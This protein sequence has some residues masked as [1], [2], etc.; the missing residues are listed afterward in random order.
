MPFDLTGAMT[1]ELRSRIKWIVIISAVIATFAFANFLRGVFT[2]LFWFEEV[3][4]RDVYLKILTTKAALFIGAGAVFALLCGTS[5]YFALRISQCP[6]LVP[7]PAG[8]KEFLRRLILWGAIV[9]V[10]VLSGVFGS[11]AA[12]QWALVMRYGAAVPFGITEP[13]FSRDAGFYV[14]TLPLYDMVQTWLLA[15]GIAVLI[16]TLFA[17]FVSYNFRGVGFP[18][19]PAFKVHISTIGASI[20]FA[21]AVGHWIDRMNIVLSAKGSIFGA[22]YTDVHASEPAFLILTFIAIACGILMLVNAYV[23]GLRLLGGALALW[24]V[25]AIAL[26]SG[27][28]NAMQRISV[29]PNEFALE[30]QYIRNNIE[31]TRLGYGLDNIQ[32]LQYPAVP[33]MTRDLIDQNPESIENIRLW[34]NGPL[35]NVYKQIQQIRPYYTFNEADIDRYM[36]G[37]ELR[38]VMLAAREVEQSQL[39]PAAQT[40]VNTKLRY[41]HGFGIAMSPVTEFTP[42]GRPLFYAKDIPNDGIIRIS[43][44]GAAQPEQLIT[45][46]RIYYGE[47]TDEY[48]FVDTNTP[49]LDYQLEGSEAK[50]FYYDGA[51]GVPINS[52]IRR[53]AYAWQFSDMAILLTNEFKAESK[54][55][56]RRTVRDRAHAIAPFLRMDEDPYIVAADGKLFWMLDAYTT[57]SHFPYSEQV[58]TGINSYNYIRNSVKVTVDAFD[59]TVQFYIVDQNDPV[60]ATYANIFPTLFKPIDAMPDSLRSHIRYANNIFSVQA[61][62]FLRYHMT[63]PQDFYN[64]EDL[65]R[66]AR[67]KV[68]ISGQLEQVEPY[69]AIMKLPGETVPEFV[70]L[71]PYT[72]NDPPIMAGW[73]AARSDG[74]NYGELQA[75]IFPRDRQVDGPEQVEAKID[76]DPFISE[77]FTLRCQGGSTCIRG[78]LLVIPVIHE[79]TY[80]L[81]YA[82]PVY[83]QAAGIEFP[84][85]K[86]VVLASGERVVMRESV[87][88]G[89]DALVGA[90]VQPPPPPVTE[91]GDLDAI[92][93]SLR[94][95]KNAVQGLL[96]SILDLEETLEGLEQTPGGQ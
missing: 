46:P 56:Y 11:I 88:V 64:R 54:I 91:P 47:M 53:L 42:E 29:N 2:D 85:L 26:G 10:L 92:R 73:L 35:S 68:G 61:E 33:G 75:L 38:Q 96:D 18:L 52:F 8:T 77:W 70:L 17:Y 62:K 37:G 57:S 94:N 60:A 28:P 15:A 66:L 5:I 95:M 69:Y 21:L 71:T 50:D 32:S 90:S 81:L 87:P 34:D 89:I 63:D 84:E 86:Q 45:N 3:G 78:N 44:P 9:I 39:G 14:F 41:T 67:E 48:V 72:R 76:N 79:D 22:S 49:E 12:T 31:F 74:D 80:G 36:I 51:G 25:A 19:N 55:M 7:M 82:E 58:G 59:G 4:Y 43:A 23:R 93:E 16:S 27:W 24:A 83:L 6:E 13:I 1:P 30:R 20:M 65:W 40:W